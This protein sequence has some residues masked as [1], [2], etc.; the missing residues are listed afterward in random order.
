ML[1]VIEG[2]GFVLFVGAAVAVV[3]FIHAVMT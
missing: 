3:I 2:A 1:F